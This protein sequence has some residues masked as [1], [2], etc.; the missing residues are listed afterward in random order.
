[1]SGITNETRQEAN[2]KVDR[3]LR[4]RQICSILEHLD[5]ENGMTA[6]EVAAIMFGCGW[7]PSNDRYYAAPRLTEMAQKGIVE[8]TGKKKDI[9]SG[10]HVAA[11]RLT[12]E[13]A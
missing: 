8:V 10:V 11:Y 9:V 12:Q 4:Y 13:E 7:I 5:K 2:E 1:M 3:R 6:R